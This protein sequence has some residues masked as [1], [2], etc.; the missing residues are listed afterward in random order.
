M[1]SADTTMTKHDSHIQHFPMSYAFVAAVR[2]SLK[3]GTQNWG[4][5]GGGRVMLIARN[6]Y[7]IEMLV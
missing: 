1:T 3:Q 7:K 4:G 5:G 6:W 2:C